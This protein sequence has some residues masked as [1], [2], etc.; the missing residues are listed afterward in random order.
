MTAMRQQKH[1]VLLPLKAFFGAAIVVPDRG[2]SPAR[3]HV[4]DFIEGE[5]ERA[6]AFTSGN[7]GDAARTHA[8]RTQQLDKGG[9]TLTLFPPAEFH[10]AQI[11]DEKAGVDRHAGGFHPV[12]VGKLFAPHGPFRFECNL[13]HMM[14]LLCLSTATWYQE[15]S[16]T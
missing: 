6:R 9:H 1:A 8:L 14:I 15:T 10:G 7:L 2:E 5:F 12:I 3:N 4:Y 16:K 13:Y 11:V